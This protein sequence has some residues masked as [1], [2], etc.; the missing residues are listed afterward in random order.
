LIGGLINTSVI[1]AK[2][3]SHH[4]DLEESTLQPTQDGSIMDVGG[5]NI[6]IK[7]SAD[8]NINQFLDK[9]KS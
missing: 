4:K 2:N 6:T 1:E 5:N 7:E 8:V 9:Y 3:A